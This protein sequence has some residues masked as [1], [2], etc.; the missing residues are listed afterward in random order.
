MALSLLS[1]SLCAGVKAVSDPLRVSQVA[2]SAATLHELFNAL[3][4][5][6]HAKTPQQLLSVNIAGF[7]YV[8]DIDPVRGTLTYLAPCSGA[9]PGRYLLLGSL[10]VNLV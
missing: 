5:V 3:L 10:K 8:S 1:G 2:L 9:L 4:G 6:S 7:V